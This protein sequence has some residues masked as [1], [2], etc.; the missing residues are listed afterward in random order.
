MR[1]E[2]NGAPPGSP[3]INS[4]SSATEGRASSNGSAEEKRSAAALVG[5]IQLLLSGT[6]SNSVNSNGLSPKHAKPVPK[7]R[8]KIPS[9]TS[10]SVSEISQIEVA[11]SPRRSSNPESQIRSCWTSQISDSRTDLAS[12]SEEV[13]HSE[14]STDIRT[15]QVSDIRTSQLSASGNRTS[16]LSGNRTSQVSDIR[17]SQLSGTRTSQVSD[18]RSRWEA[19]NIG[20]NARSNSDT[21]SLKKAPVGHS[22]ANKITSSDNQQSSMSQNL[23]NLRLRAN[24]NASESGFDEPETRLN[25]R[26]WSVGSNCSSGSPSPSHTKPGAPMADKRPK[27]RWRLG[28]SR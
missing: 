14:V 10:S 9:K 27:K 22:T 13:V 18:I 17:T 20:K 28:S 19:G 23:I 7:P 2:V 15:G 8:K 25:G 16:Q 3:H 4:S 24:S 26:A 12:E 5:G 6:D 21:S 11:D 1:G